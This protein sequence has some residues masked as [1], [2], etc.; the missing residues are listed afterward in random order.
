MQQLNSSF[1]NVLY[2]SILSTHCGVMMSCYELSKW[3]SY[4]KKVI[5][6][7]RKILGT[8]LYGGDALASSPYDLVPNIL[9][10]TFN[11]L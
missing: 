2:Y 8:R 6:C 1:Q 11:Y 3:P 9:R 10:Y 7:N 5:E 4:N